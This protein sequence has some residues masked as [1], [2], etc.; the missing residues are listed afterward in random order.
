MSLAS[1][2][3]ALQSNGPHRALSHHMDRRSLIV[4]AVVGLHVLGLWALQAG[5]LR[6]AVEYVIPVAVLSDVIEAPQPQVTPTPPQP[7][8]APVP[9]AAP[10]AQP[11]AQP[12]PLPV[13]VETAVPTPQEPVEPIK[14]QPAATSTPVAVAAAEPTAPP[15]PQAPPA[16]PRIELP[17]SSAEYLNNPAPP[18]P[19][20]S[21]RRGEQGKVVV[22]ALI[23]VNGTASQAEIRTSSG[24]DRLDQAALQ[25]VLKWRY[26]PGRRAGVP[27][28]MWFNIPI[29]FVLE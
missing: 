24:H 20:L 15:T 7:R 10:R 8:P 6:R 4:I 13:A 3:I 21:K 11:V 18:Y 25:T 5:L 27:E 22:R 19:P 14:P 12:A 26:V 17:S 2:A 9:M 23:E 28:A 16:P 1:A 29:H